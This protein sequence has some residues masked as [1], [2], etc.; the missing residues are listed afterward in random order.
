MVD[1]L[2]AL[3]SVKLVQ[4]QPKGL[5]IESPSGSIYDETRRVIVDRLLVTSKGIEATTPDG[6]HMLDIHHL[7]HPDKAFR[8]IPAS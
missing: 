6:E 7:D 3:G 4:L 5:I 1:K 2:R 8:C